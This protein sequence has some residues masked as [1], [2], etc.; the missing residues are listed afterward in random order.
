MT[1]RVIDSGWGTEL[2]KALQIDSS[3]LL[4]V[5]P[6]IKLSAISRLLM[7]R[8]TRIR[9]LTRFSERDFATGVSDIG[10]IRELVNAGAEV[11]VVRNLHA[12]LY[13]FGKSR[14][15]ITSANLTVAGLDRNHEFGIA[16]GEDE[17]IIACRKYFDSVWSRAKENIEINKILSCERKVSQYQL[18]GGQTQILGDLLDE[19]AEI[20]LPTSEGEHASSIF[21]DRT[22]AFVKFFGL[23]NERVPLSTEIYE[24]IGN[25]GSHWALTY[26][27]SRCPRSVE[28]GAV[29]FIS[30]MVHGPDIRIYGR[31][32]GLA[33]RDVRDDATE[34][35][36][37]TRPWKS[38]W[39]RYIRVHDAEFL[40]GTLENGVSLNELMDELEADCFAST[41]RNA[42]AGQG[43]TYPRSAIKRHPAVELTNE[44]FAWLNRQLESRFA[45]YGKIPHSKLTKLDWPI[46]PIRDFSH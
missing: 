4:I 1:S 35:E 40:D 28:D 44:G 15:I 38:R 23:G 29:M 7:L 9:V 34:Q 16:S 10:A 32:I 17:L 36:I 43:N 19:G 42:T 12:K 3:E 13:V 14:A 31:A 5:S 21:A 46:V 24:E 18:T 11:R 2:V 8:P 22:Q 25:S 33:Y 45:T 27:G 26:P 37:E 20:G 30:R 6:F 41:S 39:S